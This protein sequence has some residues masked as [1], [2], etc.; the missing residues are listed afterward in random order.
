MTIF[1]ALWLSATVVNI[2]I[3]QLLV[4]LLYLSFLK[5]FLGGGRESWDVADKPFNELLGNH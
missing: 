1:S 4:F 3:L 5:L 2:T